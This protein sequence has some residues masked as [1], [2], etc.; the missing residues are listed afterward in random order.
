MTNISK[1]VREALKEQFELRSTS[2]SK[3]FHA[4]DGTVKHLLKLA[5]GEFVEM[6]EIPTADRHTL[7]VSTQVGCAMA[8][9]FCY[10]G[11]QGFKRHLNVSEI[12]EQ[13]LWTTKPVTNVVFMGM[14][15]PLHNLE[16]VLG[17]IELM[18]HDFGLNLS[19]RRITVSTS[20][21]VPEIKRLAEESGP[22]NLAVSL[23]A[24]TDEI[25][26]SIMPVNRRYPLKELLEA[27]KLYSH[28]IGLSRRITF[29]YTMMNDV[30]DAEV[31]AK[32]LVKLLYGIPSKVNL[33]PMNPHPGSKSQP[34]SWE[35][36]RK[37]Q[38]IILN[39]NLV[40]TVRT[41]RGEDILA[42][43][44]QLKAK[45]TAF[46]MQSAQAAAAN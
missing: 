15:E 34:P 27:C 24:T 17:S 3:T 28:A 31:D 8:C 18:K 44:G 13:L 32:R 42:A 35:K 21:L 10:T 14:G 38:N 19:K 4:E 37:F 46:E 16:N 30:N 1:K 6:V 2:I 29:E 9:S 7:C 26:S 11:T 40:C 25:R 20:G 36:I 45:A 23:H 22:V 39:A 5:D 41:T 43:C 12:I 33:I